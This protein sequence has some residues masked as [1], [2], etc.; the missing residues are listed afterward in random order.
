VANETVK[1]LAPMA[2]MAIVAGVIARGLGAALL[3]TVTAGVGGLM[4]GSYLV[5]KGPTSPGFG[6]YS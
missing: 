2:G 4:L 3:G 6:C 1:T 5:K